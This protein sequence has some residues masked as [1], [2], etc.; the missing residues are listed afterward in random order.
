VEEEG[1]GWHFNNAFAIGPSQ[2]LGRIMVKHIG[3][4]NTFFAVT[5]RASHPAIIAIDAIG[6]I[7]RQFFQTVGDFARS[8]EHF[9]PKGFALCDDGVDA[10]PAGM[11]F[12]NF[13]QFELI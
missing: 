7:C 5:Y 1:I 10:F 12:R 13:G 3:Y 2:V 6:K 11:G 4:K 9:I 8:G